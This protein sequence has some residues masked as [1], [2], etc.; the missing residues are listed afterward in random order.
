M[1]PP[2]VRTPAE[3]CCCPCVQDDH[4]MV[5]DGSFAIWPRRIGKSILLYGRRRSVF[6]FHCLI[7]PDW[8]AVVFVYIMIIVAN[9]VVLYVSHP[10]GW[11]PILIG[12]LGGLLLLGSYTVTVCSDPGIVYKNDYP[13]IELPHRDLEEQQEHAPSSSML[14]HPN[15][16]GTVAPVESLECG[17]CQFQRPKTARHCSYCGVCVDELDHHCPW[18]GKCIGKRNIVPFY[19]FL[20]ALC[21]QFYYLVGVLVY[22]LIYAVGTGDVPHGPSF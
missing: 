3:S 16:S 1:I 10:I 7:G 2:A 12:G 5:D 14:P 22:Y 21:F 19:T 18:S 6:P 8:C 15:R 9:V 20:Y 11:P 17:I 4:E 13:G